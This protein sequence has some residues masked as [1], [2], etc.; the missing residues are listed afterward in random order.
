MKNL[1]LQVRTRNKAKTD[2]QWFEA[3]ISVPPTTG[4]RAEGKRSQLGDVGL[5]LSIPPSTYSLIL[6]SSA[7]TL[8]NTASYRNR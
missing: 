1:S 7:L 5:A 8:A 4:V 2:L 3:F 6:A